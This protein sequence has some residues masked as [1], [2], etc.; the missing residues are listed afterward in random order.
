MDSFQNRL[1]T[2]LE[3]RNKTTEQL[4]YSTSQLK[5]DLDLASCSLKEKENE[6]QTL[7]GDFEKQNKGLEISNERRKT[8][9][10]E[11]SSLRS[12]LMQLN[13]VLSQKSDEIKELRGLVVTRDSELMARN[14][15]TEKLKFLLQ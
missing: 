8:L 3:K 9:E 10:D 12:E 1:E 5:Q 14:L 7:V 15:E 13:S 2:S 6:L 4:K 11:N